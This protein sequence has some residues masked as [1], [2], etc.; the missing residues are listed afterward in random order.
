MQMV[1]IYCKQRAPYEY[2][3]WEMKQNRKKEN[4]RAEVGGGGE[5]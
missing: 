4:R 1:R 2:V 3:K 5:A